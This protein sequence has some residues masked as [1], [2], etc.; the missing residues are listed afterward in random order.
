MTLNP[1]I[2]NQYSTT[3]FRF[4]HMMVNDVLKIVDKDGIVV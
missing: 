1:N 4:G 2:Y 3:V